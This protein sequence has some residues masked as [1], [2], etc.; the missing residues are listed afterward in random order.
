MRDNVA[1]RII[2]SHCEAIAL[3][4]CVFAIGTPRCAKKEGFSKRFINYYI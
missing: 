4:A 3:H 2:K 1:L